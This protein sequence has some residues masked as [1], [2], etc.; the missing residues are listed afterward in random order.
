MR[1]YII[2]RLLQAVLT[3]FIVSIL[4]FSLIHFIPGDTALMLLGPDAEQ[5]E[6]EALRKQLGLNLPLWE[7][8]GR[9]AYHFIRGDWGNSAYY[10]M[11]V[12]SLLAQRIPIT[13]HLTLLAIVV[14]NIIGI[15]LGIIAAAK[16]GSFWDSL[17]TFSTVLGIS[18]PSFWISIVAIYLFG[19]KLRWFPIYGYTSPFDDF[20][21]STRQLIMPVIGLSIMPIARSA[22]QTR[23]AMLEVVQ[24]DFMRTAWS[25]GLSQRTIMVRHGLKM[26]LIPVSTLIFIGIPVL[27]A[28]SAI[29]E[30]VFNIPGMG[31]LLVIGAVNRDIVIVQACTMLIATFV[32]LAN[33]GADL[34]Y[35]WLDPR[36]RYD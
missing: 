21:L 1:S 29:T 32:A 20:V 10:H 12:R 26:A 13:I 15:S 28:G 18:A 6:L 23:S 4:V 24:Q 27:I 34:I 5:W 35:G 3:I 17:I 16:R 9:W 19:L 31:R 36:I 8:Y 7:Q 2:R 30:T 33:L 14:G 11:S 25:K 22:R